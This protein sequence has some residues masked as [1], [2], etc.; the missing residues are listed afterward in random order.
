MSDG[1]ENTDRK[2]P[3]IFAWF[4]RNSIGANMLMIAV[5]AIGVMSLFAIQQEVFPSFSRNV[6][7][8]T[9]AYPGASPEEIQDSILLPVE[10]AVEGTDA[11]SETTSTARESIGTV[12]LELI[13]GADPNVAL[14][15][16]RNGIETVRTF[17]ADAE[18]PETRLVSRR[19]QVVRYAIYGEID[20]ITQYEM[21]QG[22]RND[23][24]QLE[25]VSQVSLTGILEPEIRVEID[26]A[27]LRSYGLS[28][29]DVASIIRRFVTDIPGGSLRTS[30][31]EFLLRTSG[32]RDY[33]SELADIPIYSSLVNGSVTLGDVARLRDSFDDEP[34]AYLI[35][36]Q[37]GFAVL[38]YQVG[39][40]RPLEVAAAVNQYFDDFGQNLPSGVQVKKLDDSSEL[41]WG[42]I[43]LL[44]N[45]GIIGFGLVLLLLALTLEPRLAFWVAAGIP[46]AL[47]G[48][49]SL[50]NLT[51]ISLNMISLFGF[52]LVIGIVVD[53]AIIVGEAIYQRIERGMNTVEASIDG[54]RAMFVPVFLA[55]A[56]NAIAFIPLLLIPG[57]FGSI[58]KALPI[59]AMCAFLF[60]LIEA[61]FILP[62]HIAHHTGG[63]RDNKEPGTLMLLLGA[64]L[65]FFYVGD[66]LRIIWRPFA[67]LNKVIT[68]A[69][70]RFRDRVFTRV[71]DAA[72]AHS[73]LTLTIFTAVFVVIMAWQ[74][75]G[76]LPIRFAPVI[77]GSGVTA[78]LNMEVDT[79]FERTLEAAQAIEA[80]GL[81]LLD[82][83][84]GGRDV[85]RAHSI[86]ISASNN[87]SARVQFTF[88]DADTRGFEL[89]DF[90]RALRFS[91][92]TVAGQRS[93][94]FGFLRGPGA[95][96]G[97]NIELSH[98]SRETLERAALDM[99]R[100]LST[101]EGATDIND[102]LNPGKPQ[103]DFT[104]TQ[105]AKSA[106]LTV[107]D[108][109]R[110]VRDWFEGAEVIRQLRVRDEIKIIVRPPVEQRNSLTD[111]TEMIVRLPNGGELPLFEAAIVKTGFAFNQIQRLDGKEV[112]TV[113]GNVDQLVATADQ[114]LGEVEDSFMADLTSRYP[115]LSWEFGGNTRDRRDVMKRLGLGS[116]GCL[117]AI[118]ALLA[119]ALR[120]MLQSFVVM[121]TIPFSLV[122]A[123]LGHILLGQSLSFIS[124]LGIVALGGLV[125]NGA[126]VLMIQVN[127]YVAEGMDKIRAVR[128]ASVLRFRPIVLTSFT[129][130]IGLLP[131]LFETSVQARFLIPMAI[132]LSFGV[133]FSTFVVLLLIPALYGML[134]RTGLSIRSM[135]APSQ[136]EMAD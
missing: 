35:N 65:N 126:Q 85:L 89:F 51:D 90:T 13:E 32:R 19:R 108:L 117:L 60:S 14:Q 52:I 16:I 33:A 53:D 97:L 113:T 104:L 58:A 127:E 100:E 101:Y 87:T 10:G 66:A 6:V 47:I 128:E 119:A 69:F 105:E 20:E 21:A 48:A 12:N 17:P 1:T 79:P 86:E 78:T 8:V 84:F 36:G 40:Q 49:F 63:D 15:D 24:L 135:I 129:T 37:P 42:R 43:S 72:M 3:G 130:T 5:L 114:I 136:T 26:Q 93:L 81:R 73:F 76:R 45:N 57:T 41:Y 88:V 95:R 132:S 4:V 134:L 30:D 18:E 131:L 107:S 75:S 39:E 55:V 2:L 71:L 133:L 59:V 83:R 11:I 120:S 61:L 82:A 77:E 125:I 109:G 56:T 110:Q 46:I 92:P 123:L 29:G 94:S 68:Q 98:E 64:V 122:A 25:A 96:S 67:W 7:R 103:F 80:A 124:F 121:M 106:G 54:V 91:S 118:F 31:T 74:Q 70:N 34:A 112:I 44:L 102:G 115:G 38:V 116:L 111:L 22:I 27:T 28:Y 62:A 50:L 9:V 99:A 23:L